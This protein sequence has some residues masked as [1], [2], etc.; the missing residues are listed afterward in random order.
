MASRPALSGADMKFLS[1]MVQ[2]ALILIG[3]IGFA[4]W[5]V[6]LM[7]WGTAVVLWRDRPKPVQL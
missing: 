6:G 1:D 5:G 4:I 7:I 3:A 2:A